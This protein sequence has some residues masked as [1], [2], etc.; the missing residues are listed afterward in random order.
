MTA[1]DRK[2]KIKP[3]MFFPDATR[4]FL[5][6]LSAGDIKAAGIKGLVVNTYHLFL[7]PGVEIIR[8]A[9]GIHKFMGWDGPVMSDS[10]GYQVYS[11][12]HKGGA[13]M[14]KITDRGAVFKSPI[15]GRTEELTP[16]KS[17]QIQFDLG[18][19][20]MVSL[21][22]CPPNDYDRGAIAAAVDRTVAWAKRCR[23]EFDRQIKRRKI[24][25]KNRPLLFAVIQGG[26]YKDLRKSCAGKLAAIG[27]DGYGFGARH[28][29][30]NGK[31]MAEILKTTAAAVPAGAFKFALGIG[32]PADIVR[33]HRLG[34][35]MFDCVIP[36]R[37]G[38]HGRLFY[39]KSGTAAGKL[40]PDFYK[41]INIT[42][43]KFKKDF[44]PINA[45]SKLPE[46]KSN[47]KAYLYYLLKNNEALGQ[48][49]ASLHNL[50]FY[51]KLI[52]RLK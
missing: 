9:G 21:D 38:R 48:R 4:G 26:A 25:K 37:E 49:L 18:T 30:Q 24:D 19:D 35:Q 12:I 44:S 29:G 16:E 5:K 45:N 1:N 15:D 11:L 42:N 8:K 43:S 34:W 6:T 51:A 23:L 39:E 2:K 32:T 46:L 52:S 33:A 3:P 22:D 17:I 41:T 40:K 14:G 36:T 47:T 31:F 50:E 13:K 28:I 10:G 7:S 27:F 20:I